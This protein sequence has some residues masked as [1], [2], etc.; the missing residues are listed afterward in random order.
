MTWDLSSR[1]SGRSRSQ[2]AS[3]LAEIDGLPCVVSER[4]YALVFPTVPAGRAAADGY[5]LAHPGHVESYR[6]SPE[7]TAIADSPA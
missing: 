2:V 7:V 3:W 4:E 6:I 1:S 5:C